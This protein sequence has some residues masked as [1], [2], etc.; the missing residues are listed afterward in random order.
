MLLQIAKVM[1]KKKFWTVANLKKA[2]VL[3]G[4]ERSGERDALVR[5]MVE[6]IAAPCLPPLKSS[7][8]GEFEVLS[9]RA[10]L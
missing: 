5:R 7:S 3:F 1:E 8:S 2:L 9:Q 6:Y 10:F 4:L